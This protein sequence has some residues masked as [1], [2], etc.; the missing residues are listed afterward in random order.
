MATWGSTPCNL[1]EDEDGDYRSERSAEEE[2]RS[3]SSSADDGR[4]FPISMTQPLYK[5][6]KNQ[7]WSV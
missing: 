6:K 7:E 3:E 2:D 5:K 4:I 1:D